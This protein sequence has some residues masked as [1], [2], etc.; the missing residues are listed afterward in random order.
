MSRLIVI[1]NRVS[2]GGGAQGGLAVALSAALREMGGIWFG[3]SGEVT[4]A[5]TGH[6]NFQKVD[7]VIHVR[8]RRFVPIGLREAR[9]EE[10]LRETTYDEASPRALPKGHDFR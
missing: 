6:I 4:D 10:G 1:S 3:W 2:A 7:G 8:A 5:F 9:H